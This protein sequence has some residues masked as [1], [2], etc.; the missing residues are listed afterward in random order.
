MALQDERA[1][2]DG[3]VVWSW[4]PTPVPGE[5]TKETVKT[6]AQGMPVDLAEPCMGS[7][8]SRAVGGGLWRRGE[9]RSRLAVGH[10]RRR[11]VSGLER[12]ELGAK[13]RRRQRVRLR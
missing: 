1:N 11:R 2:A 5:S 8:L 13:M 7:E 3:E 6:I 12:S 10:R 4:L 9:V